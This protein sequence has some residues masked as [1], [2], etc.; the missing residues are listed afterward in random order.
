MTPTSK[1]LLTTNNIS[2]TFTDGTQALDNVSLNIPEGHITTLL[3]PSGCG[4][5]TLLRIISGLDDA[6]TGTTNWQNG[7]PQSGDIGFVFQDATL[8]PWANVWDNIYL[9]FRIQNTSRNDA[10]EA[11]ENAINLVDLNGFEN[12]HPNQLSGGM[13]MRV[14]IARALATNPSV[15]LM[16]EPFGA[17]DEMTRFRLNDDLL[18]IKEAVNCTVIFVTH[19][20]YEAVYLSD[21]I[22]V[23]S[24][25]PGRII[26]EKEIDL[27]NRTAVLRATSE[28]AQSCGEISLLLT[29]GD[30]P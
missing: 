4:K 18:R 16:D 22:A 29:E 7:A 2:R 6:S 5:S 9:P 19:S 27:G 12:H 25:R 13:R 10:N 21:K 8:L 26:A 30:A 14:S 15:L 24:P 3:G 23:M 11:I 20:V 28:F 17:L 1:P